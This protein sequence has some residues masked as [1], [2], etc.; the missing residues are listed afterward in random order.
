VIGY[1]LAIGIVRVRLFVGRRDDRQRIRDLEAPRG[2][3][4]MRTA[5]TDRAVKTAKADISDAIVPGLLLRVRPSGAKSYALVARFPGSS[6]P[7]RRTIAPAGA[8]SLTDAREKA[9]AWLELLGRG[10]DPATELE[11][12]RG[13]ADRKR[14]D[15][16]AMLAETYLATQVVGKMRQEARVVHNF[17]DILIPLF[18]HRPIAELTSREVS[19]ALAEIEK[20]G[21][22]R[23]LVKLGVR[24]ELRRPTRASKPSPAQARN[25]FVYL[26]GMLRW[27]AGTGDYGI[28][29]SPLMR[30]SKAKRFGPAP[31][32]ARY[33]ND[34]E[35]GAVWRASGMLRSPYRQLYRM[36][37]L[38]GLRLSEV[39]EADWREFD[40]KAKQWT[41]PAERMKGKNGSAQEHTVPLTAHMLDVLKEVPRGP[42]G[43]F[44]FSVNGGASPIANRGKFKEML[45]A[46][47]AAD[48][49]VPD[50]QVAHFTNHDLRRTLRT[51]G[52][53]LG[54]ASDIGEA[55]L[56]HRRVGV[57]GI[58]DHDDRLEER[59]AAHELWGEFLLKCAASNVVRMRRKRG[60]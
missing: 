3:S 15:T 13:E 5:L 9:R 57:A 58:Y 27:A 30:V 1:L 43:P 22:D 55:I 47:M 16:I 24:K 56:A 4:A 52:R 33:L 38:T 25:L 45:D 14:K 36:L 34:I 42:R 7:T 12:E 23:G 28:E 6:N 53:K 51:R 39:L 18:G 37:F 8:I 26:D 21:T 20:H 35:I 54:I 32:R 50:S 11:R 31:R 17:R 19:L 49:R 59:R 44:V 60:G 46:A 41:I 48:L 10:I 2:N 29:F 40:L